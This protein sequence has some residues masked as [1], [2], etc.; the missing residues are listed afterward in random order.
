MKKIIRNVVLGVALASLLTVGIASIAN[1]NNFVVAKA[2]DS[3]EHDGI[4]FQPWESTDSVPTTGGNYY[5]VND[6]VVDS[7]KYWEFDHYGQTLN[8]DFNGHS[9]KAQLNYRG[10]TINWYD[11]SD[12]VHKYYIDPE[13]H[14]GI[15]N[16][17]LGDDALTFKGGYITTNMKIAGQVSSSATLNMYGGNI[18]GNYN[19]SGHTALHVD[20][21]FNMYGGSIIG[22][23]AR[24]EAGLYMSG[25]NAGSGIFGMYGGEI[26]NNYSS[27]DS[28]I[29]IY[30]NNE[31]YLYSGRITDNTVA[32]AAICSRYINDSYQLYIG[33]D[34]FISG[35]YNLDGTEER[36]LAHQFRIKLTEH[37]F[38]E[39][40][41]VGLASHHHDSNYR[42]S[43]IAAQYIYFE[44][45]SV[46]TLEEIIKSGYVYSDDDTYQVCVKYGRITLISGFDVHSFTYKGE[47]D[48]ITATCSEENCSL[49]ESELKLKVSAPSYLTYDGYAKEATLSSY[50]TLIFPEVSLKYYKGETEV[51]S[52]VK[53]GKYTAVVTCKGESAQVEFEIPKADPSVSYPGPFEATYGQKVSEFDLPDGWEWDNPDVE[54]GNPTY[55]SHPATYTPEDTE[56]Y[57]VVHYNVQFHIPKLI[58]EPTYTVP[59]GLSG[60]VGDMLYSVHLP[61]GWEWEDLWTELAEPVGNQTF[62]ASWTPDSTLYDRIHDIPVQVYVTDHTHEFTYTVSGAKAIA[63]CHADNCYLTEDPTLTIVAPEDLTY[64]G[65]PKEATCVI[66]GDSS[67]F[68]YPYLTYF[69]GEEYVPS[70]VEAGTYTATMYLFGSNSRPTLEFTIVKANPSPDAVPD[71]NAVYGQTLSEI[72]LPEGWAWNSPTDKVGNAGTNQHK[73][74][75]TPEDT[76]NYNTLEQDVNVIVAK[77][78][79]EYTVPTGLTGLINRTLASVILPTG[80]S[81][82]APDTNLGSELG[83]KTFK[84]TFTPTDTTNY[85]IVEHIDVKVNISEHEHAWNYTAS[86]ASITA[87]CSSADCP[88]TSGLTLTLKAPT[89]DMHYDGKV[90]VATIEEGYSTEAFPNPQIKYFTGDKEVT[91]CV[92]VGKYIAKVTFGNAFAMVEFEILGNT[93]VDPDTSDVS[94]EVDDA[95]IPEDVELR[96]EVRTDVA[97]KEIAE[98][99]EKIQQMLEANEQISKVY[100]VKLIQT[101]GGVEKEIQPSDIKPGLKITVKMA[102]PAGMNMANVRIL[103]IHTVDDMEFVSNYTIDGNDLVFEIDR[104]SQ[105]A[106]ITKT[107]AP[108]PG[109]NGGIIALIV[110]LSIVAVLGILFLLLF[111]VFAKFIIIE[112]KVVKAVKFGKEDDKIRL[113]TFKCKK[114]LRVEEEVFDKKKDAED[115]LNNQNKQ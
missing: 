109:L 92:N 27:G 114:Q 10:G 86:G 6:V 91:E 65:N 25:F 18:F 40:A 70:C 90:R 68:D 94:I 107:S 113:F 56:I 110:I 105:F 44:D 54:V 83:E 12:V 103:H 39:G 66:T 45:Y 38:K 41:R 77:A 67:A 42:K 60:H 104:L 24:D 112:D 80:W 89:G 23:S 63:T 62:L 48:T 34:V 55:Q 8:F 58:P 69:K 74:T 64:D 32:C 9:V 52:C 101:I 59:T 111:F 88:V 87:S 7:S 4:V 99:Y 21:E 1:N 95:V 76:N 20:T 100:D 17:D 26:K 97:E 102:I 81:W 93:I 50:N 43:E 11:Y 85:N 75:F 3:V 98:D 49:S 31:L 53:P 37:P 19:P 57:N 82:E 2:Y 46:S 30:S 51:D 14:Q 16:E 79:P 115:F 28:I 13:T 22:N 73:A 5:L 61:E 36:N 84:A 29:R 15:I 108:A 47:G 35:N 71:Q 78:N 106:F 96:V 72:A 33:G